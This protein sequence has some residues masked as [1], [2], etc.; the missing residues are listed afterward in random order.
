MREFSWNVGSDMEVVER[1]ARSKLRGRG[2]DLLVLLA[3]LGLSGCF[4]K[5]AAAPAPP[6]PAASV[7]HPLPKEVVEWDTYSGNLQSPAM[8]NVAARVSGLIVDMPFKEGVS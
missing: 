7:A 1:P 8:A 5:P 4:G 6:P 3:V 2:V